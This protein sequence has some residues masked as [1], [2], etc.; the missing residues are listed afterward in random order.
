MENFCTEVINLGLDCNR[1]CLGDSGEK[2]KKCRAFKGVWLM[3][4]ICFNVVNQHK[5]HSVVI[6]LVISSS[7]LYVSLS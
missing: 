3:Q 1:E 4:K 2:A 6:F 5:I 7:N